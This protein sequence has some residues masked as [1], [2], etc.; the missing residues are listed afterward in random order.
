MQETRT[1]VGKF[2]RQFWLL[3]P[4]LFLWTLALSLLQICEWYRIDL[5]DEPQGFFALVIRF[6]QW[7][8]YSGS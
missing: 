8:G 1:A 6:E 4:Y 3:L 5:P 2:S 7:L